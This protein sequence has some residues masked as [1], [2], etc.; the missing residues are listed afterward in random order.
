MMTKF[1]LLISLLAIAPLT[2]FADEAADLRAARGVF[3]ANLGAI[4]RQDRAAYLSTYVQDSRFAV[5]TQARLSRDFAAF[6]GGEAGWPDT[7]EASDL[8]LIRV[9]PGVVYGTYR[10]R[11]TYG[12]AEH[13]GLSQRLFVETPEGWKIAVTGAV[14]APPG[15]PPPPRAITGA[16]LVD[17]R[18]GDP[19]ANANVIVRNGKIDCAGTGAMPGSGGDRSDRRPRDVADAGSRR[20]A[21]PLLADRMGRRAT[22]RARRPCDASVREGRGRPRGSSGAL[23]AKLPLLGRDFGVRRRRV[24]LDSST[25]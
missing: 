8:D 20:R 5:A 1:A 23:R 13:A 19:V 7:F 24:S 2:L 25:A 14:D 16:T 4:A 6:A 9:A 22:R 18:G 11:I 21:R 10:Y 3:E 12:N 17:G 15:T